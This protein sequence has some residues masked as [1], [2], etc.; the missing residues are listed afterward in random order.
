MC[1]ACASRDH[2]SQPCSP[3]CRPSFAACCCQRSAAC[4]HHRVHAP[5][6]WSPALAAPCLQVDATGC[7]ILLSILILLAKQPAAVVG[8]THPLFLALAASL[9]LPLLVLAH[10]PFRVW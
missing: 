1:G 2:A 6:W 10:G 8:V 3:S 5:V 4:S 7:L 9:A